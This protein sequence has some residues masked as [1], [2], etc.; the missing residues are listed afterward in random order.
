ML[1][2]AGVPGFA[3]GQG[4]SARIDYPSGVVVHPVSGMLY[5]AEQTN[6]LIRACTAQ[7]WLSTLAGRTGIAGNV[8]G[9][10]STSLFN[11]PTGIVL[12]SNNTNLYVTCFKAHTLRQL[13][14][15]TNWVST[16][17]G[18]GLAAEIDGIGRAAAFNGPSYDCTIVF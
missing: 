13:V 7:G 16:I 3:D 9:P 10:S 5:I 14:L 1:A 17:A 12:D 4:V 6:H 8:D 18:S 11:V 15:A 2:G